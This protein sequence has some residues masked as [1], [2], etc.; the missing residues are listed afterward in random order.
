MGTIRIMT[1]SASMTRVSLKGAHRAATVL[2]LALASASPA[3]AQPPTPLDEGTQYLSYQRIPTWS[4]VVADWQSDAPQIHV[5]DS[6]R[7]AGHAEFVSRGLRTGITFAQFR[8]QVR[9]PA[10]RNYVPLFLFDLRA[11]P[12][13]LDGNAYRWA[14]RIEDYVYE[15]APAEMA[16]AVDRLN[17]LLTTFLRSAT[18]D[19]A[20]VLIVLAEN[21]NVQPNFG[22]EGLLRAEGIAGVSLPD[23]L[24]AVGSPRIEILNPVTAVGRLRFVSAA[25]MASARYSPT[26]IVI[27]QEL[28]SRVPPVSGIVTLAPQTPLSHVNLLARNRGTLNLYALSLDELPGAGERL[29]ELVRISVAQ[30]RLAISPVTEAEAEAHWARHRP[31]AVAIPAPDLAIGGIVDLGASGTAVSAAAIG[32]KASNYALLQKELPE[33]VRPGHALPLSWYFEAARDPRFQQ[34]QN[35][36]LAQKRDM[37][38]EEIDALLKEMRDALESVAVDPARMRALR[39]LVATRYPDTRIRLRSSTNCE[40]LPE[41]NG[42][43]LYESKGFNTGDDDSELFDDL[44][45]VYA[46]LWTPHAFAEREFYGIDH[47]L[48]GMGVLINEAFPDEHANGVVLTIPADDNFSILINSQPGES[49]V[50]NPEPGQVPES[51][52]FEASGSD[53]FRLE[54]ESTIGPV[55]TAPGMEALL[56]ELKA[57][58]IGIHEMMRSTVADSDRRDFGVDI[59]FKLE[60]EGDGLAL[61]VKQARLLGTALPD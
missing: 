49:A 2:I 37:T 29:G 31:P 4:A 14:V 28:P 7:Y 55:F 8:D 17:D 5:Y 47:R 20:S 51:I 6:E 15:D 32:A 60:R 36:L 35:D 58:S 52:L 25:D 50:T 59:E 1:S 18:G 42:A 40:D 19:D 43:G 34:L 13:E 41:F 54:S 56:I 38:P 12:I 61:Y 21:E 39:E 16:G 10:S 53:R 30:D 3:P 23:V 9:N 46:S 22:I 57:V 24:A 44:L 45:E 48:A 11:S 26:D 33:Y 27:F